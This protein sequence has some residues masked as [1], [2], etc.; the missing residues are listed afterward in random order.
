RSGVDALAVPVDRF[1]FFHERHNAAMY[2]QRLGCQKVE[3][4][5]ESGARLGHVPVSAGSWV[6][7]PKQST[8]ASGSQSSDWARVCPMLPMHRSRRA[9]VK[10]ALAS[11]LVDE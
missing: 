2:F 6:A 8:H 10:T 7:L 4:F 5:V 3:G 1:K 9:W 11:A